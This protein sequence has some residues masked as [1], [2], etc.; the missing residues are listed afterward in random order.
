M[1]D[2]LTIAPFEA[3]LPPD[4]RAGYVALLGRPNTGKSTLLNTL[5]GQKLSIVSAKPQTTRHRILGI[6]NE[7]NAQVVFF[8]TPGVIAPQYL[9]HRAMM[10]A[11]EEAVREADA[12]LFLV[13]A[14]RPDPQDPSLEYLRGLSKPVLLAVNKLDAV[15]EDQSRRVLAQYA[16]RFGFAD[17][18]PISALTGYNV[19]SLKERILQ[20]IPF[21]PP[22]YPKELLS[23]HPER[24][25]VA[26][27]I[28]E[29]IFEL[30]EEEIPYSA[31]VNIVAFKERP[32][33]KDFIDAEIVLERPSQRAIL[34]GRDGSRIKAL[35]IRA[36]ADIEAFLGRPV[37]LQLHVKVRPNW[38]RK[39][40]YLRSY[41]YKL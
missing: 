6:L 28:R 18:I 14:T 7:E 13:D 34:L 3:H 26:E 2:E 20:A 12:V 30:F 4:H 19:P 24:F 41:G 8:D 33:G 29:K 11:V 15:S 5:L 36:R 37:Y 21:G 31:Q 1:A 27:L 23:A 40:A 16:D 25:F 39:A 9:L 35:G 38:R 10:R 17:L 22:F 32:E